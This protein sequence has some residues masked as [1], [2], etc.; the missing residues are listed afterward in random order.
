MPYSFLTKEP[1]VGF[2]LSYEKLYGISFFKITER[3][4]YKFQKIK[5]MD[6]SVIGE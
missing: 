1:E 5:F 3:N 6:A 4:I 2:S